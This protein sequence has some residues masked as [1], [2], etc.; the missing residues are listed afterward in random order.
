MTRYHINPKSG[1]PNKCSAKAGNCPFKSEDGT[2][3]SHYDSPEAARTGYERDMESKAEIA[4]LEKAVEAERNWPSPPKS[5]IQAAEAKGYLVNTKSKGLALRAEINGRPYEVTVAGGDV[6]ATQRLSPSSFSAALY[7]RTNRP[8][9]EGA[10]T[11]RSVE[12]S[13]Y[14]TNLSVEAAEEHI[15]D[16]EDIVKTSP[17][18]LDKVNETIAEAEK[19]YGEPKKQ[20][21]TGM[22]AKV[23]ALPAPAPTRPAKELDFE[24]KHSPGYVL[25]DVKHS[26]AWE[27]RPDSSPSLASFSEGSLETSISLGSRSEMDQARYQRR[28]EELKDAV[29]TAKAMKKA[30][31]A[32]PTTK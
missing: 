25:A 28:I 26:G 4:R 23:D 24:L 32:L 19:L 11:T 9:E 15:R 22:Y 17:E 1:N 6:T 10:A 2:E 29:K 5:A 16:M 3:A 30:A 21:F 18:F 8:F 20:Y 14:G 31:Q 13:D 27:K 7:V 12:F